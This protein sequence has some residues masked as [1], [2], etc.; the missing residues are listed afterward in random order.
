MINGF[1]KIFE[2]HP[3]V[4][5]VAG[6]EHGLA[7]TQEDNV[8]YI[9]S[10]AGAKHTAI[11][12]HN[13]ADFI[14]PKQGYAVLDFYENHEVKVSFFDPLKKEVRYEKQLVKSCANNN[15]ELEFFDR[16]LP[17]N[18]TRPVSTQYL[19]GKGYYKFLG[20][21]YR[22]T[23][24]ILATF[25]TLD[26]TS[27]KGGLRIVKKGGGMQTRS[28][29]LEDPKGREYVLRSVNK[30]PEKALPPPLRQT[31]A[32]EVIQDQIS[33]AHPYGTL[34]VARL[35]EELGI[36]HTNPKIVYLPDDPLLGV[37]REEFGDELFV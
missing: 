32:K 28:L 4:I 17:D 11:K 36:V 33:S 13:S 12:K 1:D 26:L 9:I 8:N 19:H 6:H 18:I 20:K 14:Y 30:Y 5:Q 21:N 25:E 31:I 15:S 16:T 23:W 24:A 29:R 35:A 22:E 34:A 10:G 37:Y 2:N 3:S 7:L 27:A